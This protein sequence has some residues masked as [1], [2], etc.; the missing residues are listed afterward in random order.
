[1][2]KRTIEMLVRGDYHFIFSRDGKHHVVSVTTKEHERA[3]H[4]N[5]RQASVV[6]GNGGT[7]A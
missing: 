7:R 5:I 2:D 6:R 3:K 1:M 4:G